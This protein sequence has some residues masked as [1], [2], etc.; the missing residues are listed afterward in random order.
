MLGE[1]NN[2]FSLTRA[3]LSTG[4]RAK[5]K[6]LSVSAKTTKIMKQQTKQLVT[7]IAVAG[8]LV[9]ASSAL[10]QDYVTGTPTLSNMDPSTLSTA[11]NALY[12][13]WAG[14]QTAISSSAA[15]LEISSLGYGS[16]YYVVPTP[17]TLNVNDAQATLT[18]TVNNPANTGWV[19]AGLPFLLNDNAGA[20][21]LGGYLGY[22]NAGNPAGVVWQTGSS[23]FTET[24]PLPAAMITAIQAGNDA[25]YGFNLELDP[26]VVTGDLYDV[27]FNSLSLEPVPE[28]GTLALVCLGAVG[29]LAIRRRQ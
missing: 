10:A 13:A 3:A 9:I 21:T 20:F 6:F 29:L 17:V 24:V 18:V 12:S 2:Q 25:I 28:P 22:Q 5:S 1:T 26:A 27:T 15:G 16:L 23:T 4:G 14:A 11:P 7:A 8:S 19:W